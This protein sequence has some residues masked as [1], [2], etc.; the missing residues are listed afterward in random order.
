MATLGEYLPFVRFIGLDY[1]G[2]I[3]VGETPGKRLFIGLFVHFVFVHLLYI[4]FL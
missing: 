2:T 1:I 3:S 4:H